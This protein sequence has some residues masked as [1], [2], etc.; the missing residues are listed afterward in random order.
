MSESSPPVAPSPFMGLKS[1]SVVSSLLVR[2]PALGRETDG[3]ASTEKPR[4][5][6]MAMRWLPA[7][8]VGFMLLMPLGCSSLRKKDA[9]TIHDGFVGLFRR[10]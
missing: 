7:G 10:Q 9:I 2:F 5:S 4:E 8:A 6:R 3:L 1:N